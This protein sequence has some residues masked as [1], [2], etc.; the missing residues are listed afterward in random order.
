MTAPH[1]LDDADWMPPPTASP[2][3]RAGVDA[4]AGAR[5]AEAARLLAAAPETAV[6][7]HAAYRHGVAQAL[8]GD[9]TAAI[10]TWKRTLRL[11]AAFA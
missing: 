2:D 4:L 11:D 10:A 7:P 1:A 5:F 9:T 6:D 3:L 8:S